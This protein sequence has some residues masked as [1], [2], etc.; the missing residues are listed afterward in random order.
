MYE[1]AIRHDLKEYDHRSGNWVQKFETPDEVKLFATSQFS[2]Y[3]DVERFLNEHFTG[4]KDVR[5]RAIGGPS[6]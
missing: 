1:A 6:S 5:S 4:M 3:R 2:R